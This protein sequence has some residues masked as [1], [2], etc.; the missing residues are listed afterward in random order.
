MIFTV[1]QFITIIV[2]AVAIPVAVFAVSCYQL[3]RNMKPG[4]DNKFGESG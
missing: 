1:Q 2:V 3:T 4:T